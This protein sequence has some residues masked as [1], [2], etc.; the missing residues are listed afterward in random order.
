[1]TGARLHSIPS[2]RTV[3]A[4]HLQAIHT[5][6]PPPVVRRLRVV[7]VVVVVLLLESVVARV[8]LLWQAGKEGYQPGEAVGRVLRQH[9]EAPRFARTVGTR[10]LSHSHVYQTAVPLRRRV[11]IS[12]SYRFVVNDECYS[13]LSPGTTAASL[14][15][16]TATAAAAAAAAAARTAAATSVVSTSSA[17]AA[18]SR[19]RL[20]VERARVSR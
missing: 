11:F 9:P 17:P 8:D 1:V 16:A 6:F 15:T 10:S 5:T 4:L 7:V 19:R 20:A 13:R 2:V 3:R 12:T 18:D 14:T